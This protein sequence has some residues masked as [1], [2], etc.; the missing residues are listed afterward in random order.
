MR[1]PRTYILTTNDEY[2]FPLMIGS[3]SQIMAFDN[4]P[5]STV[6][7]AYHYQRVIRN[8]YKVYLYEGD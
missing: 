4:I 2:E 6:L 3:L 8:K 7:N 1:K 5:E